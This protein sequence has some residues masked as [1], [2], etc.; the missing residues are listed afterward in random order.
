MLTD[1]PRKSRGR[2]K[3][4][5]GNGG[6]ASQTQLPWNGMLEQCANGDGLLWGGFEDSRD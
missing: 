1:V 4:T 6:P 2:G 5:S 3:P